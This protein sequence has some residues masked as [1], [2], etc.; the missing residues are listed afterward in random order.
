M[1]ILIWSSFQ[2]V[3]DL[4][5]FGHPTR[6]DTVQGVGGSLQGLGLRDLDF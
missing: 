5:D 3:Q 4:T 2:V 6:Q 1:Y